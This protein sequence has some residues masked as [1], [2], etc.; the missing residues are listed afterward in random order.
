MKYFCGSNVKEFDM[1]GTAKR[2]TKQKLLFVNV[3][4]K[5]HL[6]DRCVDGRIILQYILNKH[7]L[8]W[9]IGFI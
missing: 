3:K 1:I 7:A 2:H 8:K 6:E 9:R 4:G 5:G